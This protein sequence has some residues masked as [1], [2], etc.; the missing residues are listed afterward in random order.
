M[1]EAMPDQVDTENKYVLNVGTNGVEKGQGLDLEE[2][3][4]L[5]RI[6]RK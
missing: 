3:E 6:L 2:E 5:T 4:Q 1:K